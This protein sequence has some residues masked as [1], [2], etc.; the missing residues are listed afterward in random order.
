MKTFIVIIMLFV[1]FTISAQ[2]CSRNSADYKLHGLEM[3]ET[4]SDDGMRIVKRPFKWFA[5]IGESDNKQIAIEMAQREAQ[6]MVSR[7]IRNEVI[8]QATKLSLDVN[9][10]TCQA[11]LSSW[12][13]Y[14]HSIL[15]GC[16]PLGD[17]EIQYDRNSGIYKVKAK[18]GIQGDRFKKM[19]NEY[20]KRRP[21]N[22]TSV[23]YRQFINISQ[24]IVNIM[25]SK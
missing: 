25:T 18:I 20:K 22:L 4:L 2:T 12:K 21:A 6:S 17:V 9:G 5:G 24:T 23:E 14:S 3:I 16:E 13:Q 1:S 10:T 7:I 19:M 8:D 15:I 11:L